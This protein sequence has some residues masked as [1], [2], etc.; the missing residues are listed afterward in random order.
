MTL[1]LHLVK[2]IK[3][4]FLENVGNLA[5]DRNTYAQFVVVVYGSITQNSELT[6]NA[7]L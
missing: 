6:R 4:S 7:F 3:E 5:C 2:R 1:C